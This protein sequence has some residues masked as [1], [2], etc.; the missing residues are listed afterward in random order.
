M[1]V[2]NNQYIFNWLSATVRIGFRNKSKPLIEG[3]QG[4]QSPIRFGSITIW[5]F[6]H[7]LKCMKHLAHEIWCIETYFSAL[8]QFRIGSSSVIV[9]QVQ[10][11]KD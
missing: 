4:K 3:R 8:F 11:V 7:K 6:I 5:Y 1:F 9:T 10:S 2:K